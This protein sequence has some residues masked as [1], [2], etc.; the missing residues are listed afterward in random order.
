M[1][2]NFPLP[3]PTPSTGDPSMHWDFSTPV[4]THSDS[5][6][7]TLVNDS[8]WA[9]P[10]EQ[11][12]PDLCDV[13]SIPNSVPADAIFYPPQEYEDVSW[14]SSASNHETSSTAHAPLAM[15]TEYEKWD[16][17]AP[18]TVE[19]QTA[20][21]APHRSRS[22]APS[23][24]PSPQP[25]LSMPFRPT[26]L[27]RSGSDGS[28]PPGRSRP[29]SSSEGQ[30][31]PKRRQSWDGHSVLDPAA[32][33]LEEN[34]DVIETKQLSKTAHS[35]IERRYRDNL[36][37]KITQLGQI[38]ISTREYESLSPDEKPIEVASKTRKADVLT[39]AI[40][41]VKQTKLESKANTEEISFLKLRV[42]ALDKVV[43]CADC[44]LRKQ[45]ACHQSERSP[46]I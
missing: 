29:S 3:Y 9:C 18:G 28:K 41:Y 24:T 19:H 14:P 37:A 22:S 39:D 35:V 26:S 40:K 31:L 33:R 13:E 16:N 5:Y 42:A 46:D 45:H 25:D 6:F 10:Q 20:P 36:N 11:S 44:A 7:P 32:V 2:Q 38:L 27:A 23:P 4:N 15:I 21:Q 30:S 8:S 1:V 12:W 34:V 17:A 43:N